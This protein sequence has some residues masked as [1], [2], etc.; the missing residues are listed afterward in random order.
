MTFLIELEKNEE[1]SCWNA[2]WDSFVGVDE[3]PEE[4]LLALL[5][6]PEVQAA[7]RPDQ[8]TDAD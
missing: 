4:A 8:V 1:E 2:S 7:L 5:A 3:T 6:F